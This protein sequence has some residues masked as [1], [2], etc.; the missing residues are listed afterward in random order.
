MQT[1]IHHF[2][3]ATIWLVNVLTMKERDRFLFVVENV[4]EVD[5][6]IALCRQ[7]DLR[8]N[9]L[10]VVGHDLSNLISIPLLQGSYDIGMLV[11]VAICRSRRAE[12]PDNE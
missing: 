6:G 12:Q 1:N 2:G 5:T 8:F 3:T 4:G 10:Q 7:V 11:I 9:M